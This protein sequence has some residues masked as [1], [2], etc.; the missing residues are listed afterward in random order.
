MGASGPRAFAVGAVAGCV[1]SCVAG[2]ALILG[3]VQ[4]PGGFAWSAH[5]AGP[6]DTAVLHMGTRQG[7]VWLDRRLG[8]QP[9]GRAEVGLDVRL[10][11]V[12]VG[13]PLR[14]QLRV[15][16]NGP[17]GG[18]L[19]T[20][21]SY[22]QE[23]LQGGQSLDRTVTLA[24]PGTYTLRIEPVLG[25]VT[26]SAS[27]TGAGAVA[28][29]AWR[30]PALR[31]VVPG[32]VLLVVG[33][34]AVAAL[35]KDEDD[36]RVAGWLALGAAALAVAAG[37]R[38][39]VGAD[40]VALPVWGATV[41][42]VILGGA[43]LL[44]LARHPVLPE[45][46][47]T[48]ARRRLGWIVE[49]AEGA[50]RGWRL[51]F[52]V[53][54][55]VLVVALGTTL[56]TPSGPRSHGQMD[57]EGVEARG[58]ATLVVLMDTR[59]APFRVRAPARLD[60]HWVGKV[61]PGFTL[62]AY[63]TAGAGRTAARLLDPNGTVTWRKTLGPK[64]YAQLDR[65]LE[66]AGMWRLEIASRDTRGIHANVW[67]SSVE[68]QPFLARDG[69][70]RYLAWFALALLALA[71]APVRRVGARIAGIA[72][73][74]IGLG[75]ALGLFVGAFEPTHGPALTVTG[76]LTVAV[77]T[78]VVSGW[79][80]PRARRERRAATAVGITIALLALGAAGLAMPGA[81]DGL[82]YGAR[83]LMSMERYDTAA[84]LFVLGCATG[85]LWLGSLLLGLGTAP[86]R[87]RALSEP[88]PKAPT[89][90]P[91]ALTGPT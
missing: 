62:E 71:C 65:T 74:P 82:G 60:A 59:G 68:A 87:K 13:P 80:A 70:V 28:E 46:L 1:V 85:V 58:P 41:G 9:A 8:E 7:N 76:T 29:A 16:L 27:V 48:W 14:T 79:S 43:A 89:R 83:G 42:A 50:L 18:G 84:S 3:P 30:V 24:E 44:C 25:P 36:R 21:T 23:M 88:P 12:A 33:A 64:Q 51:A 91:A 56:T 72:L 39:L 49:P 55:A 15:W 75:T 54:T 86:W 81:T 6:H 73:V 17:T 34:V 77:T 69:A 67:G 11:V 47:R 78:G 4:R 20:S 26:W 5:D 32:L 22:L 40:T 90:A 19:W 57:L 45:G 10:R 61:G 2:L 37:A 38:V 63:V 52:V 53:T 31:S 66:T 35:R